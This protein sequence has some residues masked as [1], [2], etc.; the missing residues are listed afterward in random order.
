MADIT[1]NTVPL[2]QAGSGAAFELGDSQAANNLL[3]TIDYN[4]QVS[5][6]N[7]Q[8]KQQYAQQIADSYK[9]NQ[10]KLKGGTLWQPEIT[11]AADDYV[12]FGSQLKSLGFNPYSPNPND[13][14]QVQAAEKL[15][16]MKQHALSLADTRDQLQSQAL[17]NEK[18]LGAA[19]AGTYSPESIANHHA[20]LKN[21]LKEIQD[22]NIQYHP[23]QK[24]FNEQE[25]LSKIV[26][27]SMDTKV[28][29]RFGNERHDKVADMKATKTNVAGSY[30]SSPLARQELQKNISI[31]L[32]DVPG[33]GITPATGDA[34]QLEK[35]NDDF[36]RSAANQ[37]QLI[38][39]GIT[40]YDDPKYQQFIKQKSAQQAQAY[41]DVNNYF[42]AKTRDVGARVNQEHA[43]GYN[44][45]Y[46]AEQR[47]KT[48]FWWDN[49]DRN[50]DDNEVQIGNTGSNVPVLK[51]DGSTTLEKGAS[52]FSQNLNKTPAVIR[53]E[54]VTNLKTNKT[55][56]NSETF[57]MKVGGAVMVPTFKGIKNNDP[58]N[59]SE[60]SFR[61]FNEILQGKHRDFGVDNITFSP[62]IQGTREVVVTDKNGKKT[63]VEEPI[64]TSYDAIRGSKNI[65][66]DSFDKTIQHF[67]EAV[68]SAEYKSLSPQ[69]RLDWYKENFK[70]GE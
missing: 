57:E 51:Q 33:I 7:Q 46:A 9:E 62:R 48:R 29:D 47:A 28:V 37:Q 17:A 39:R 15:A 27:T 49:E 13:P 18:E 4:Q 66:T 53:P 20:F 24:S 6:K 42:D 3:N 38:D 70:L 67:N 32:N 58:R 8:L 69:Q 45:G 63:K 1:T 52:L 30:L 50:K 10:L 40:S 35:F 19:P 68:N 65:K 21:T 26:P 55:K 11:K 16:M 59:G 60:I 64:S 44:F 56:K 34:K 43:R 61:Q 25:F 22:Q 2:G 36:Y 23:L 41:K 5:Q 54:L 31:P 12:N 14:F